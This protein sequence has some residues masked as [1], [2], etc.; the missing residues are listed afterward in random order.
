MNILK[1][2]AIG[3]MLISSVISI[4]LID[5]YSLNLMK[6]TT[7]PQILLD[8]SEY[9][10]AIRVYDYSYVNVSI[11]KD[12][13]CL[14]ISYSGGC[15]SHDF[16]LIGSGSFSESYPVQTSMLLSHEDND[17]NCDSIITDTLVFDLTPLKELYIESYSESSGTIIIY[18]SGYAKLSHIYGWVNLISYEF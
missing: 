18:L 6:G 10:N 17:D 7:H 5:A 1:K 14:E 9:D 8:K 11:E 4:I 3:I 15:V 16:S 2:L 13:L 12:L